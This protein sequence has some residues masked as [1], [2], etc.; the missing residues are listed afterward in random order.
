M[1]EYRV[2][3]SDNHVFEPP[4]LWTKRTE[5][6]FKDRAPRVVREDEG[7]IWVVD[8]VMAANCLQGIHPGRRFDDLSIPEE[9]EWTYDNVV[10]GGYIP[11]EALKDMDID[12]VDV[13][14]IYPTVGLAL[15]YCVEDSGLFSACCRAY[16]D[17]I[18]EFCSADPRRL[19]GIAML[20]VDDVQDGI[21][22][23]ER[24][25]DLG[26]AGVMVSIFPERLRYSAPEYEPFWAAAQETGMPVAL[27]VTTNRPAPGQS[28]GARNVELVSLSSMINLD[29]WV[30]L[31]LADIILTGVFERYPQLQMGAVEHELSWIPHFLERME[32]RYLER[33][34][35]RKGYKFQEDMLPSDYFHRN[36]FVGFQADGLGVRMRDII[37]VDGLMWGADYPHRESTFPRSRQIIE[38]ILADCTEEEKVKI[39][40]GNAARVYGV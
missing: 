4:D 32:Y 12:G 20:N 21:K 8:G 22:E 11:E 24:C 37:G 9:T 39:A 3:S 26:F 36:V 31:S 18:A 10:R 25:A 29:Y 38:E 1:G 5:A 23:M 17:Y 2:I 6:R 40:G 15:Y 16:N 7:D 19:K 27:H 30:R 28:F 14:I 34:D 13:G 33:V 35:G